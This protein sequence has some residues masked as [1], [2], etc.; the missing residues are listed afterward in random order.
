MLRFHKTNDFATP[1]RLKKSSQDDFEKKIEK[2]CF[3]LS[4]MG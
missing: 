2:H 3:V 1:K 4:K